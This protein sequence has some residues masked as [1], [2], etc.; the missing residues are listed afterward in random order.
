MSSINSKYSFPFHVRDYLAETRR[1]NCE[2]HGMYLL[3]L[4]EYWRLDGELNNDDQ[5]LSEIVKLDRKSF[6][7][8][9]PTVRKMFRIEGD[10]LRHDGLDAELVKLKRLQEKRREGGRIG[11]KKRWKSKE[12]LSSD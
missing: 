1:L 11:A 10:R 12:M 8:H 5:E 4:L 3:L 7:K 9:I 2:Q 6:D